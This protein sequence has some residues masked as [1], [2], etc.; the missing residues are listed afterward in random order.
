MCLKKHLN[1]PEVS[2]QFLLLKQSRH[3]RP[4]EDFIGDG[5]D[6]KVAED[7]DRTDPAGAAKE[8]SRKT[9]KVNQLKS[10]KECKR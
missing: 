2:L 9:F 5:S 1:V 4:H 6:H 8:L 3:D 10:L 7:A